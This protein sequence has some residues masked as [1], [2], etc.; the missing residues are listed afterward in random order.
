MRI[1]CAKIY[2]D[3]IE[4]VPV[5]LTCSSLS[6]SNVWDEVILLGTSDE[7]WQAA[8]TAAV[9]VEASTSCNRSEAKIKSGKERDWL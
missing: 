9:A 3:T 5:L 8:V 6:E 1:F 2:L 4:G 7:V